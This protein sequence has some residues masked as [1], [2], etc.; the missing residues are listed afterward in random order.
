MRTCTLAALALIAVATLAC[1]STSPNPGA[2]RKL[3]LFGEG[4]PEPDP[5]L[6]ELI[7]DEA[8]FTE[9]FPDDGLI[10][11]LSP[12]DILH[13]HISMIGDVAAT[14]GRQTAIP[15]VVK[16]KLWLLARKDRLYASRDGK[17]YAAL[18]KIIGGSLSAHLTLEKKDRKNNVMIELETELR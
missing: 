9:G 16:E 6:I 2:A 5:E 1:T 11:E 17:S 8:F 18:Q 15:V 14:Q 3:T 7:S 10:L 12:G 4:N 13:L